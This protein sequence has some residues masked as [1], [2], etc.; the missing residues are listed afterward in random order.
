[1]DFQNTEQVDAGQGAGENGGGE[2]A[3]PTPAELNLKL[4]VTP[5]MIRGL[6]YSFLQVRDFHEA[7]GHPIADKPTILDRERMENRAKWMREEIDEFLD[8]DRHTAVDGAD[9]MIDLIYFAVGTLVEMG[10]MPQ[11]LMDI[12]HEANMGKLHNIDGKMV[13]VYREDGKTKK[14]DNW[15]ADFAPEPKLAAEV[16]RQAKTGL[17]SAVSA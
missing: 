2:S 3:A 17:L 6:D 10:I 12:V 16:H 5:M 8:P 14:P 4:T 11:S 7:F 1:M 13:P 15:E 9:A